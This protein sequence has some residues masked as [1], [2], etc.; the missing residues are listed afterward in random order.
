MGAN[1]QNYHYQRIRAG[2]WA[3]VSSH[4]TLDNAMARYDRGTGRRRV[5]KVVHEVVAIDD[6]I[7]PPERVLRTEEMRPVSDPPDTCRR[8]ILRFGD[9][10]WRDSEGFYWRA[11]GSWYLSEG[12][13]ARRHSVHPTH[14]AETEVK[15]TA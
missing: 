14:W 6:A 7:D 11:E 12:S 15:E 1:R 4:E 10:G 8:V 5:V 13:K 9:D 2:E 3:T